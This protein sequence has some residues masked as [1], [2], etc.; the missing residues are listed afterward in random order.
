MGHFS[1]FVLF[2]RCRTNRALRRN[3]FPKV[4]LPTSWKQDITLTCV[5][6]HVVV[7]VSMLL[8]ESVKHLQFCVNPGQCKKQQCS[9]Y[10]C[11]ACLRSS[12]PMTMGIIQWFNGITVRL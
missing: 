2:S 11:S 1:R 8:D 7:Q 6:G 3:S 10:G 12:L 5:F 9:V 4:F